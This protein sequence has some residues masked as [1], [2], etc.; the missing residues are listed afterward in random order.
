[1]GTKH[2]LTDIPARCPLPAA[3]FRIVAGLFWEILYVMV[4]AVLVGLYHEF[5]VVSSGG[6]GGW[7]TACLL[8]LLLMA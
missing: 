6:L 7:T 5:L 4:I 8:L 1:M 3:S 2:R